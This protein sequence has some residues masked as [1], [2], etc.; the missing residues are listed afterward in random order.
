MQYAPPTIERDYAPSNAY[1]LNVVRRAYYR[2]LHGRAF[3]APLLGFTM[4]LVL[5][6]LMSAEAVLGQL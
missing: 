3:L 6:T 4:Y 5:V 1:R 2:W